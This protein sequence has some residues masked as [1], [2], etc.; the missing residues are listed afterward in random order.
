MCLSAF[1]GAI[2]KVDFELEN[3]KIRENLKKCEKSE[4]YM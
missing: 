3:K 1:F 2:Y 4:Y